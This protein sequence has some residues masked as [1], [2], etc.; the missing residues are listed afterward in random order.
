[1]SFTYGDLKTAIR[2]YT[3]VDSN[4][5]P[6]STL[7]IIVQNTENR[8]YRELNIDAFRLYASAVTVVGNTTISVPT[9]L[10]NIRYVELIDSYGNVSNLLQKDSSWLAEYNSNPS[11]TNSYKEPK[12]WANWNANTWF[13]APTPDNNYTINIAYYQQPDSITSSTSSTSY[14]SVYAQDLLL[15]GSL[16][17]TYK[18]LKGPADMIQVYEQSYQQARESFGVEQT[19]RRRRD[20]YV[21]GEPRVVVDAP[22]PA[23]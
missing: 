15:Y 6:D 2:T 13:V 17:E 22:P 16:T 3:E 18:Y 11:S 23:R 14:V 9:G 20:E 21:D 4:G 1:M 10:R 8:I 5:L 12:Y 19:G 7:D